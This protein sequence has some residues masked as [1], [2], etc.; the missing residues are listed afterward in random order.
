MM[1]PENK[2]SLTANLFL[3]HLQK[4]VSRSNAKLLFD[5]AKVQA[6]FQLDESSELEVETAKNIC[7]AM[8]KQGGPSFQVG[9]MIYKEYLM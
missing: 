6:G 2:A 9:Q 1:Q 5:A 7:L 3:T 8:I 4:R